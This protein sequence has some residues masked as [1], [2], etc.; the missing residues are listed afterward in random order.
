[1]TTPTIVPVG[2]A[3]DAT[4]FQKVKRDTFGAVR[5]ARGSVV[6]PSGTAAGAFVGLV[7]FNKGA[8]FIIH[9]KSV[10]VTDIDA[11]TDSLVNLGIIYDDNVTYTNDVDAF[12]SQSNAGQAGG[13]LAIDETAGLTFVAEADGWLALENDVNATEAEG[14]VT[15]SVGVVYDN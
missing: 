1:M 2:F 12:V 13:F 10:H 6:I 11:G 7:P 9:D 15:F 3:G 4:D 5:N 14:T 8:S